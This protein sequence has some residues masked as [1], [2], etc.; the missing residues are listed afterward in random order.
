MRPIHVTIFLKR[1][2]T[3]QISHDLHR[4]TSPV[5]TYGKDVTIILLFIQSQSFHALLSPASLIYHQQISSNPVKPPLL[6]VIYKIRCKT[7]IPWSFFLNPLRHRWQTQGRGPRAES[8]PPPCFIRPPVAVQSSRLTVKEELHYTYIVLKWHLALW[9]QPRGWCG[10]GWKWVWHP[11]LKIL[12][13]GSC[14]FGPNKFM[15]ILTGLDVVCTN[16][17]LTT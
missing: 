4:V 8:G 14:Q 2:C 6:T 9:R 16:T 7:A 1:V 15:Q 17:R 11:C 5:P 10:P 13:P 12:L 3:S